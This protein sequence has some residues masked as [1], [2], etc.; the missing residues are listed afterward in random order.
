METHK[1]FISFIGGRGS[2]KTTIAQFVCTELEQAGHSCIRQHQGLVRRPL[3]P[4]LFNAIY[5]WRF[6]DIEL[7]KAFGFCGRARRSLPSLYRLYL[8]LAFA[9]DLYKLEHG[10]SDVLVYDSNI[11][12]GMVSAV[13]QGEIEPAAI[14]DLYARKIIPRVGKLVFAVVETS[15]EVAIERWVLRD[16]VTLTEAER[17][18]SIAERQAFQATLDMVIDALAS[19]PSV[20]VVRL[21]GG[22]M[23]GD[24]SV[25][26]VAQ[27]ASL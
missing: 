13:A 1:T 17:H 18:I 23:P 21:D 25:R 2:G 14:V 4:A 10:Q 3:L 15:P 8:P 6:F 16:D 27:V 19:L 22:A 11:L 24:N 12:R 9:H 20:T 7:I 26:V 5:L